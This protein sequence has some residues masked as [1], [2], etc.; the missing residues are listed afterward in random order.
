M[1]CLI[2]VNLTIFQQLFH[3]PFVEATSSVISCKLQHLKPSC[4]PCLGWKVVSTVKADSC[5]LLEPLWCNY[6]TASKT[7]IISCFLCLGWKGVYQSTV[8][9]RRNNTDVAVRN[10]YGVTTA[11]KI[12]IILCCLCLGREGVY[13]STVLH[14]RSSPAV[15]YRNLHGVSSLVL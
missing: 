7:S 15:V 10:L 6:T 14:C 4:C 12:S 8:L 1:G 3:V 11:N 13:Q 5:C 2:T 9:Y